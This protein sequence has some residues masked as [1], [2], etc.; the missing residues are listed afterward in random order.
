MT[1]KKLIYTDEKKGTQSFTEALRVTQREKRN[2]E[3]RGSCHCEE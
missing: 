3:L 1:Q 2:K